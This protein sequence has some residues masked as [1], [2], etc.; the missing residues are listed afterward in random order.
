MT[1]R[2]P[3]HV[4][5]ESA[6]P[7]LVCSEPIRWGFIG[8]NGEKEPGGKRTRSQKQPIKMA[9]KSKGDPL[10]G[11]GF[12]IACY[13]FFG[14]LVHFGRLV[15]FHSLRSCNKFAAAKSVVPT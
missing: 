9:A 10:R 15:N 14:V 2:R 3:Q 7:V 6:Q 1:T 4:Y 11:A 5:P 12:C 8:K 13:T